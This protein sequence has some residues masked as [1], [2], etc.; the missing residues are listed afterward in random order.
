MN[1][2]EYFVFTTS[3]KMQ[4]EI[5]FQNDL[6]NCQFTLI[7]QLMTMRL[8]YGEEEVN[9]TTMTSSVTVWPPLDMMGVT[10]PVP[11]PKDITV[12]VFVILLWLYSIFLTARAYKKLLSDGRAEPEIQIVD[13]WR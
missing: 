3:R 4:F 11:S 5:N 1:K 2:H 10:Q 6:T 8:V 7:F 13:W 9:I 12:I